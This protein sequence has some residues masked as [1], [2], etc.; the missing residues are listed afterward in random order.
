M[1]N[2][3]KFQI[4]PSVLAADM[5]RLEEECRR[6]EKA[7][8]DALH[9]DIMDGHFVPNL[10]MGPEIVRRVRQSVKIPLS[11]HLMVTRPDFFIK[12]FAEAGADLLLIHVE[13]DCE[14]GPVLQAIKKMKIRAGITLN[15]ETPAEAVFPLLDQ[16]DEVLFM[17]V[18]PGYGGQA[19]IPNVMP[20]I[21]AV[22]KKAPQLDL[23]VDG[24]I[25]Q[26][27]A[28]ESAAHGINVFIAGTFL[29]KARDMAAEIKL[30]RDQARTHWC[31]CVS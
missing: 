25:N 5:G 30:M 29:F 15:P 13:A 28:K 10:S 19:F 27:T 14:P 20:K 4:L 17:T 16:V 21:A 8:A 2:K 31:S 3:N 6:A 23:S 26:E 7:G 12:P 9:L 24:G 11:V 1:S 18:H 22:R